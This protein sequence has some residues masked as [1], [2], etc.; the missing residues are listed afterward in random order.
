MKNL[1]VLIL[2]SFSLFL[3]ANEVVFEAIEKFAKENFGPNA[4]IVSLEIRSTPSSFDEVQLISHTRFGSTFSF[5]FKTF[6]ERTF[7]GYLRAQCE[8]AIFSDVLLASRT[9][10]SGET[11]SEKDV[12]LG[13]VNLLSLKVEY[14][15]KQ[16]EVVGRIARKMFRQGEPI[17]AR[18]LMKPPDVK[19][20][21]LLTAKVQIGSVFVTTQVRAMHDAYIGERISVRNV[22]SGVMIN[23]LLQE[24]LTVVV[25]G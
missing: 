4:T 21:Q 18:Y 11:F 2:F 25:G 12:T 16:E 19:A 23:G 22:S 14:C 20:G 15:V 5:L 6:R 3:F 24:D 10:R 7:C 1:V 13:K 17:D 9:I 8:L